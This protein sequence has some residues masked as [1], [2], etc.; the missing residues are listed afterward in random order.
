MFLVIALCLSI[1]ASATEESFPGP[2][3]LAFSYVEISLAAI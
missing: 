2:C 1:S 3:K